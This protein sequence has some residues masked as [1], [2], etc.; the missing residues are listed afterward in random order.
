MGRSAILQLWGSLAIFQLC[1]S[2]A[3]PTSTTAL[4]QNIV[5]T[6]NVKSTRDASTLMIYSSLPPSYDITTK[7]L[8]FAL[9]KTTPTF[10][11]KVLSTAKYTATKLL[12]TYIYFSL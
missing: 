7:Y 1:G 9:H 2:L 8:N 10:F 11:S 3:M 12:Y 4:C 6:S 5:N